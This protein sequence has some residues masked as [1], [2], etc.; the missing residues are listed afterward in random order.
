MS[1][2]LFQYNKKQIRYLSVTK[3]FTGP[4]KAPIYKDTDEPKKN[5]KK[6]DDILKE[7][8]LYAAEEIKKV[9][10]FKSLLTSLNYLI[11]GDV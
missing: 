5:V 7:I 9:N 8:P 1:I 2:E 4:I 6:K 11:W 10:F 3:D